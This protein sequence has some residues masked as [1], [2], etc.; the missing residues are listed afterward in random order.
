MCPTAI[1]NKA[2]PANYLLPIRQALAS[3]WVTNNH[4]SAA[5]AATANAVSPFPSALFNGLERDS[6]YS[7]SPVVFLGHFVGFPKSLLLADSVYNPQNRQVGSVFALMY[8]FFSGPA[9]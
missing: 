1:E 3:R 6:I 8:R 7:R 4:T 2:I 9:N 5:R